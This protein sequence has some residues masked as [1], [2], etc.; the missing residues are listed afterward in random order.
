MAMEKSALIITAELVTPVVHAERSLTHMDGILSFAAMTMHPVAS[1]YADYCVVPLPLQLVWVSPLGMP[2]WACTPLRP[3]TDALESREYWH[4]RYPTQRADFGNRLNA[5]T[6]AGRWKEYRVPVHAQS[7]ERLHALVI[8][9]AQPLRDL[10]QCVSHI[11]KKGS[12]GYGRVAKWTVTEASHSLADVLLLRPVPVAYYAGI[13][14]PQG[15]LQPNRAWTPPYWFAPAWSD[16]W[17]PA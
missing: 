17:M 14:P 4:K 16:C 5:I 13:K 11:G 12:M 9:A 6:S 1:D 8:G 2:L 7:V 10:L 3:Q 15:V